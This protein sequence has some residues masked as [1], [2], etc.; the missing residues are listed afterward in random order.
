MESFL[1]NRV[2]LHAGD[3]L[4]VL[5]T[6]AENSIDSC[7]TDPPY[8]LQS[9][10][11][12]RARYCNRRRLAVSYRRGADSYRADWSHIRVPAVHGGD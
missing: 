11:A 4:D 3:C 6:F 9:L 1:N 12:V 7:V 2:T 5:P 8:H 10:S